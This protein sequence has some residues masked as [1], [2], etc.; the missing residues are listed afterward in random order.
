MPTCTPTD[1]TTCTCRPGQGGRAPRCERWP[2]QRP[3]LN[4]CTIRLACHAGHVGRVSGSG[5]PSVCGVRGSQGVLRLTAASGPTR[6]ATARASSTTC[7]P[8]RCN[9]LTREG[10]PVAAARPVR[11]RA[12]RA[13]AADAPPAGR[14]RTT[15][16]PR[17]DERAVTPPRTC[18]RC[19]RTCAARAPSAPGALGG[20]PP[21]EQVIAGLLKA[22]RPRP[23]RCAPARLNRYAVR[24]HGRAPT[25]RGQAG[26]RRR[27][28]A[29]C[30]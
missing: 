11:V 30:R 12:G 16:C 3:S 1:G 15:S 22:M 8:G 21:A 20:H 24:R 28:R 14:S 2:G 10:I 19:M 4:S 29:L 18:A 5:S 25:A 9:S 17:A 13:A 23:E 6:S 26:P 27:Y 7:G